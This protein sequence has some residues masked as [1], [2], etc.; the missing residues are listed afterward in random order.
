MDFIAYAVPDVTPLPLEPADLKRD[1]MEG[2]KRLTAARHPAMARAN[3]AG[4]VLRC[5]LNI[6]FTWNGDMRPH[7]GITSYS[8]DP[9]RDDYYGFFSNAFGHGILTISIPYLFR[10]PPGFGL[11]VRGASNFYIE[12]MQPL[13]GLVEADWLES[14]F[15]MNWRML[16]PNRTV[17]FKKGDPF[18][19]IVPYPLGLLEETHPHL[20]EAATAIAPARPEVSPEGR[21]RNVLPAEGP[22]LDTAG[23]PG[24]AR[25]RLKRFER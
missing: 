20:L 10:T 1:W 22:S 5:P 8:H 21:W 17:G 2:E 9:D 16:E 23:A 19:M 18:C 25:L 6:N 24:K 13:D 11:F 3:Q 4:W 14:S 12:N 15:T 7:Q